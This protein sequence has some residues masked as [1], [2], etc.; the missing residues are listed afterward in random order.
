MVCR[1]PT[2]EIIFPN[3]KIIF[4]AAHAGTILPILQASITKTGLDRANVL[5]MFIKGLSDI[6]TGMRHLEEN[7]LGCGM[8]DL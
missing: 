2:E 8:Y 5:M 7:F 3:A 6:L 4:L 1:P